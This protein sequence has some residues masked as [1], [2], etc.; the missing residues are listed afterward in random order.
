[1]G[2]DIWICSILEKYCTISANNV[3]RILTCLTLF[4][5]DFEENISAEISKITC[6]YKKLG[7]EISAKKNASPFL[8][9]PILPLKIKFICYR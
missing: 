3:V 6:L 4:E 7:V 5:S 2:I 8:H 9:G 1:M